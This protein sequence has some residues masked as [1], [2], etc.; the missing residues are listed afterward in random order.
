MVLPL[1]SSHFDTEDL[2]YITS[3]GGL[4]RSN[5]PDLDSTIYACMKEAENYSSLSDVQILE[6]SS[7]YIALPK[8][9]YPLDGLAR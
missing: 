7:L 3:E 1:L 2:Y 8:R 4:W 6:H 9:D 5:L